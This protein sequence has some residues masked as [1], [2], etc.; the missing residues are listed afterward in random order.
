[1]SEDIT[2]ADDGSAVPDEQNSD[3]LPLNW[4]RKSE[5]VF[6]VGCGRGAHGVLAVW[7]LSAHPGGARPGH[8]LLG[9]H[10]VRS[11]AYVSGGKR[12]TCTAAYRKRRRTAPGGSRY[13]GRA[14]TPLPDRTRTHASLP[15]GVSPQSPPLLTFLM[16]DGPSQPTFETCQEPAT[17]RFL[18]DARRLTQRRPRWIR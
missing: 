3:P 12:D 18:H 6:P 16:S 10:V 4:S 1:M 13:S 14:R 11:A 15:G 8:K 5:R 9:P 2:Q 7:G 17:P